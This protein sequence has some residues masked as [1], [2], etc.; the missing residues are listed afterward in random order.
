[1]LSKKNIWF[2]TLF[3]IILVMS[4][5]YVSYPTEDF[6]STVNK[7]VMSGEDLSVTVNESETITALRINRDELLEKELEEIKS[8]LTDVS[9]TVEEK[10]DAY[11]ALKTL[12]TNKGKEEMVENL[13][14]KNF[15]YSNFVKIDG[16]N[17][18]IV[19]DTNNHSYELANKIIGAVQKEFDKRVYITVNFQ[20]K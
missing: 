1:M 13:I 14:K 8:I 20:A 19:V 18:K 16:S 15:N 9:K 2:L 3:S 17:I 4:I 12:N 10:S 7:E 11:E 5:Y 6:T